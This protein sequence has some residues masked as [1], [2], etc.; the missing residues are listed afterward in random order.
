[1]AIKK[2]AFDIRTIGFIN[3]VGVSTLYAKEIKRFLNVYLQTIAA[4]IMTMLLF[5]AIF[6]LA[7]GGAVREVWGM[8]FMSFLAPGIIMMS[9]AQNAFANPSSSLVI[10]K[11]QGNIVDVIMPPLS[12]FELASAWL[13]AAVTRG[14]LIGFLGTVVLSFFYPITIAHYGWLVVFSLLGMIMLGL[15]GVLAGVWADKF[16][17][18]ATITNFVITPLTFLSGTF[19][20]IDALPD[21]WQVVAHYNPFFYM[22]DG[23]RHAFIGMSDSSPVLGMYV[24]VAVDI[25]LWLG[26]IFVLKKGYKIK[27]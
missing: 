19:Y 7:L 20:S 13:L 9:M 12:A 1:M 22:I 8:P 11:I 6:A 5:F 2:Q 27:S 16:D 21:A 4:P 25:V 17:H 10:A 24:L 26:L 23:F 3:W 18:I 14:V 15:L